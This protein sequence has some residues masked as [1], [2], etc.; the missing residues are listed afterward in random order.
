MNFIKNIFKSIKK[1]SS[2]IPFFR[3]TSLEI[4]K[5]LCGIG[6]SEIRN[7]KLIIT[8]YPFEPSVVYPQ[9]IIS[10][11]EID[12][13]NVDFGVCKIY[14]EGDIVFV[15]A[16]KKGELKTFAERNKIELV[17]HSWNW[18]WILEPY[19]DTEFDNEHFEQLL[20]R[21]QENGI[22]KAEVNEL[23]NEVG[24]QMYKYNF[25]TILWEW[26][27]L[28]L[29]DVLSAMREKYN[30]EKFKDFYKRAVEIERRGVK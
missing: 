16:E 1:E 10:A 3:A 2:G 22:E 4:K 9:R 19:L 26:T 11:K 8:D 21:L 14:V 23:R 25:D 17:P 24:K 29:Y 27:S 7:D 28:G 5:L 18:D 30:K 15:S 12:A 20:L 6:E 13:I